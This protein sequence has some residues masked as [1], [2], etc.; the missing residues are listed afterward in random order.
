MVVQMRGAVRTGFGQ[1]TAGVK[2]APQPPQTH[3]DTAFLVVPIDGKGLGVI[4]RRDIQLGERIFAEEPLVEQ[5]PGYHPPLEKVVHALA[6]AERERFFALSQ[7]ERRFGNSKSAAGIFATNGIPTHSDEH[8]GLFPTIARFNHSCDSNACYKWSKRL[9]QLT[10][11][12]TKRIAAGTEICVSYGFSCLRRE[13]RRRLLR[14]ASFGFECMC[15]KCSLRGLELQ[16]SEERLALI[17]DKQALLAELRELS[18]FESLLSCDS[19]AVLRRLSEK[20]RLTQLECPEGHLYDIDCFLQCLVEF[21]ELAATRCLQLIRLAPTP[22]PPLANAAHV[23]ISLSPSQLRCLAQGG[24][25][26]GGSAQPLVHGDPHA[27]PHAIPHRGSEGTLL[28]LPLPML[29]QKAI[30]YLDGALQWAQ[31]ALTV[32]RD[33]FGEDHLAYDVWQQVV[34]Q[35]T[36]SREVVA[37]G[38]VVVRGL[39]EARAAVAPPERSDVST[40]G[41]HRGEGRLA[42]PA[43]PQPP[44]PQQQPRECALLADRDPLGI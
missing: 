3:D 5:G 43:Q 27:L 16:R 25:G 7:N 42:A 26:G 37:G 8:V 13:Q 6:P 20:Y 40:V 18:G 28:H 14:E 30:D 22:L 33:V 32:A 44:P 38:G 12:A 31:K 29:Q 4:A 1:H 41:H 10:V 21:C 24:G 36:A 39:A 34:R 17:G 19:A 11:H 23:C 15:S 9:G 2:L 35:Y